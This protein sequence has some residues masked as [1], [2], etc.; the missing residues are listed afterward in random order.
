MDLEI[1]SIG[2][3]VLE[4][5]TVNTNAAFLGRELSRLGYRV[6]RHTVLPDRVDAIEKGLKEAMS[7]SSLVIATG[8]LGPTIDDLTTRAVRPLFEE[9]IE[10]KNEIGTAP[11]L[12][13][14]GLILLPG[15]PREMERMFL[16]EALP[17][18]LEQFAL[19]EPVRHR[20]SCGLCLLKEV[21]VDPFLRDLQK[22]EPHVEIGIYPSQGSLLLEFSGSKKSDLNKLA[23][24]VK[25]RF[26]T[27]YFEESHIALAVQKEFIARK[28]KLAA[29]ESC[30][31]GA[32]A[33][34]LTAIPDSSLYF[35]GS[36]VVYSNQWKEHFLQVSRSTLDHSGAVSRKAV[37]E[38]VK[39]LFH[40]TEADFAV[41]VSGIAGPSGGTRDKPVG[42]ICIAIGE[43]GH[44]TDIGIL[45]APKDRAS[46]IDWT[47]QTTL[48]A[49]WRR[50]AHQAYTF[51]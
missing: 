18:I 51:S 40:E 24:R 48:G 35:L 20:K 45:Q 17:L 25:E 16:E 31:G 15:P 38:M 41:A 39:G 49:L 44:K 23:Q 29:A 3:E 9:G 33:A 27:F 46:A 21:E 13:Y 7:R 36:L 28:K 32:I 2:N 37:D 10:L 43:R 6:A 11:G 4:G 26:P 50:L 5:H 14:P 47:V 30:T 12:F 19:A 22:E 1:V 42:T 34:K 8:G